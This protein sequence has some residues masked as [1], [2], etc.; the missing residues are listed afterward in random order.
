MW[1]FI[2]IPF[3]IAVL[4]IGYTLIRSIIL[5]NPT[6]TIDL[7][8]K[9]K[10]KEFKNLYKKSIEVSK[11]N[12]IWYLQNFAEE[13]KKFRANFATHQLFNSGSD[14]KPTGRQ[15]KLR[16][17]LLNK[18]YNLEYKLKIAIKKSLEVR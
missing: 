6:R 18:M 4:I 15:Y 14:P 10:S 7:F 16:Y 9:Q 1:K 2:L 12:N 11:L 5:L 17:E 3:G 8:L 13:V